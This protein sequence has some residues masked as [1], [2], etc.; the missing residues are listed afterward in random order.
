MTDQERI[1]R[2]LNRFNWERVLEARKHLGWDQFGLTPTFNSLRMTA[3]RL[4][5]SAV[6]TQ[7]RYEHQ[8]LQAM[9]EDGLLT[10]QFIAVEV[11]EELLEAEDQ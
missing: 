4:L 2:V 10:L 6:T 7:E 9:N 8:G 11:E 5:K 3:E 1:D